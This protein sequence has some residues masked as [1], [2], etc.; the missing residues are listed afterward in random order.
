MG[1]HKRQGCGQKDIS[2]K[3][4]KN[5]GDGQKL[6]QAA[7]GRDDE[8]SLGCTSS[9]PAHRHV[10]Y[11]HTALGN[12]QPLTSASSTADF[13]QH[14]VP[15]LFPMISPQI[16]PSDEVYPPKSSWLAIISSYFSRCF[17]ISSFLNVSSILPT[18]K[19][20]FIGWQFPG[21]S[22]V[23]FSQNRA[24]KMKATEN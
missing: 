10:H 2:E 4:L 8:P 9:L 15:S 12:S 24:S 11:N 23:P 19:V 6:K 14:T 20:R 1:F 13:L 3:T 16:M 7:Q 5:K 17:V 21:S 18:T 22:P